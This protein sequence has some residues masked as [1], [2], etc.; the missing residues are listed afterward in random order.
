M[1]FSR[2]LQ[3]PRDPGAEFSWL[4]S[5]LTLINQVLLLSTAD[6]IYLRCV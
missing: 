4:N 2:V 1:A 6:E 3:I 5:H